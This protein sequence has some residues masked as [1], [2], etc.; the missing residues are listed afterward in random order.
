MKKCKGE[1][2]IAVLTVIAILSMVGMG[3]AAVVSEHNEVK[4]TDGG[5]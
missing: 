2:T 1:I 3:T 4:V 5:E